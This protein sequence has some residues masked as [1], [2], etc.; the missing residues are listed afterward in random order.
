MLEE[1]G[2]SWLKKMTSQDKISVCQAGKGGAI[3]LVPP[4]YLEKKVAEKLSDTSLYEQIEKDPKAERHE[5]L[6]D[7]WRFARSAGFVTD[8]E[9]KEIVGITERDNKSTASRFKPGR[10]YFVPSLKIHKLDPEEIKPGCDIPVRLITCLQEGVTK[11]SDVY[12]AH[13][14]LRDLAKDYCEDLVSD[15]SGALI[16]L[17]SMN[18]KSKKSNRLFTPFTF[19]F[20]SL[21]DRLD[22]TLVI[23][24]IRK[25][26]ETCRPNWSSAFM[27]WMVSLICLSM[28]S[29]FGEFKQK[30]YKAL[31]GIASGGSICVELANIAVYF[32]LNKVLYADKKLMRDVVGM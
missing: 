27:D 11:R 1:R 32:I 20:D 8:Q 3:L 21:Y 15:S 4:S 5:E 18:V 16:C 10:T 30:F 13:K 23:K 29:A 25:A 28:D 12:I 7:L 14:W 22:P 9:A 24:A 6:I 31:R 26:M 19:D 17:E 2:W